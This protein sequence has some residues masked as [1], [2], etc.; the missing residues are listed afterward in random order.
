M[1]INENHFSPVEDYLPPDS[2]ITI[3]GWDWQD[4]DVRAFECFDTE[5]TVN[6]ARQGGITVP[7]GN[8]LALSAMGITPAEIAQTVDIS[9]DEVLLAKD[10]VTRRFQAGRS[11]GHLVDHA[12]VSGAL[13]RESE[14]SDAYDLDPI[15]IAGI[16]AA[17]TGTSD[18][19][20]AQTF[21]LFDRNSPYRGQN[22]VA[23]ALDELCDDLGLSG[24]HGLVTFG[25]ATGVLSPNK[26]LKRW[27]YDDPAI[28]GLE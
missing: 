19:I 26:P 5:F 10:V 15:Y 20:I 4:A 28:L 2:S 8:F 21:A 14:P 22:S 17:A 24:R 27:S 18:F 23:E 11:I 7:E 3:Q 13:C 25:H 16:R 12:F 1:K 9:I 6:R